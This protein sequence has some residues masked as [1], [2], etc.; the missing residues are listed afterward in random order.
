M[1]SAIKRRTSSTTELLPSNHFTNEA[2]DKEELGTAALKTVDW[3]D[4]S[5]YEIQIV[6]S[7]CDQNP[8]TS[9]LTTNHTGDPRKIQ[10]EDQIRKA[11]QSRTFMRHPKLKPSK[12]SNRKDEKN[13]V[14]LKEK[15]AR[16]KTSS[17]NSESLTKNTRSNAENS[18]DNEMKRP[19]MKGTRF[20]KPIKEHNKVYDPVPKPELKNRHLYLDDDVFYEDSEVLPNNSLQDVNDSRLGENTLQSLKKD[21]AWRDVEH[22]SFKSQP[23]TSQ[24]PGKT[25]FQAFQSTIL[26]CDKSFLKQQETNVQRG[27]KVIEKRPKKFHLRKHQVLQ[28]FCPCFTVFIADDEGISERKAAQLRLYSYLHYNLFCPFWLFVCLIG[29]LIQLLLLRCPSFQGKTI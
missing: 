6:Q 15:A 3:N 19:P 29:W 23:D 5:I 8:K 10:T 25:T 16:P 2:L 7:K 17:I 11:K 13:H 4:N 28:V 12:S 18:P 1:I 9:P 27:N 20:L 21:E 26:C 22:L 14:P 24:Q